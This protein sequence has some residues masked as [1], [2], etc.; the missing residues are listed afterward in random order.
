MIHKPINAP[1]TPQPGLPDAQQRSGP[2]LMVHLA[3]VLT[4]VLMAAAWYMLTVAPLQ[5]ARAARQSLWEEL[6]PRLEKVGTLKYQARNQQRTLAA[7]GEQI[8]QG[9]LQLRSV[10]QINQRIADITAAAGSF[11]LRLEEVKPG[12]PA[13]MQWFMNVP[14][15]LS[16]AGEYPDLGAFLHALPSS[17][18]DVAVVGF[19]VRGEPES[20]DK[21]P[22]FELNLVWYAAPRL[23]GARK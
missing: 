1:S 20:I 12:T 10:D 18:P 21:T 4:C 2:L 17:F 23:P 9:E 5:D 16:G 19:H 22:R 3:G 13:A 11:K 6:Q 8:A 15:K 14:I 7:V